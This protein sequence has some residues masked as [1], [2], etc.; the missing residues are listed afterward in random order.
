MSRRAEPELPP[1]YATVIPGLEEVAGEEIAQE[2]RGEVKRTAPGLVVFRAPQ[3]DRSLL[4][5]R[6]VEDVFLLAWGTDKLTYR[7][8]DLDR[9][10]RWTAKEA[11]WETLLR[12]HH[13]IT[14]KPKGKPTYRLVT[15]MHGTR[16]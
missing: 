8:E 16:R 3:V 7:A 11:D 10:Q 5:L 14:P 6:T 15:Q 1:C 2:L 4:R 12:L 13:A 9:I